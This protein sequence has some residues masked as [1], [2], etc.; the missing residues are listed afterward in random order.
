LTVPAP[1]SRYGTPNARKGR[2][3]SESALEFV[4]DDNAV[5]SLPSRSSVTR[6][7]K[8]WRAAGGVLE[9]VKGFRRLKGYADR[10][11]LVAAL[12]ARDRQAAVVVGCRTKELQL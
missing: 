4:S 2:K 12:R 3:R 9:A 7:V 10:P 11:R 5:E 8:R 6:N 1:A